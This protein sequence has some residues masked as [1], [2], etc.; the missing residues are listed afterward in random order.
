LLKIFRKKH[1]LFFALAHWRHIF[2][3]QATKTHS[4]M[5]SLSASGFGYF[6]APIV[7]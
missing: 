6:Y 4:K 7:Q 1:P 2:Q 5:F 3:K